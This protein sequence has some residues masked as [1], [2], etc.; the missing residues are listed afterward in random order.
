MGVVSGIAQAGA[1]VGS[2]AMTNQTNNEKSK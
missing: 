2:T 1:Q